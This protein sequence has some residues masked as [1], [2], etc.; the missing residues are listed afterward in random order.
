MNHSSNT[1][2]I[3]E[4]SFAECRSVTGGSGRARIFAGIHFEFSNMAKA[5]SHK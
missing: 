4:L 1:T 3:R 5:T 2:P